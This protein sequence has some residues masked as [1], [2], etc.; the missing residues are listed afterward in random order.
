MSPV[1]FPILKPHHQAI[2][3]L[4]VPKECRADFEA[5]KL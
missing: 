5:P 3:E 4:Y 2:G 1:P